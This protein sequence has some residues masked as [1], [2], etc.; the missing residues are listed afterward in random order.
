[1]PGDAPFYTAKD[2]AQLTAAIAGL[3][4]S[5]L[6]CTVQMNALVTGDASLGQVDVNGT[7]AAYQ[8]ADGWRLEADNR[9]VTLVG[10]SCDAFKA[11]G[12]LHISFPCDKGKPVVIPID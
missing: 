7:P 6:S 2:Q 9:S 1:M 5:V 8:G 10:T 3:L 12:Q 4:N 11:T